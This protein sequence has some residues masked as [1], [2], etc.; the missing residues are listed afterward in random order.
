MSKIF[1]YLQA[2]TDHVM[3]LLTL[4]MRHKAH[5]ASIVLMARVIQTLLDRQRRMTHTLFLI[6]ITNPKKSGDTHRHSAIYTIYAHKNTRRKG[7]N[8]T[9]S[10]RTAT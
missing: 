7:G 4:D 10:R 2:L 9:L 5:S 1:E 6:K 3:A 8:I